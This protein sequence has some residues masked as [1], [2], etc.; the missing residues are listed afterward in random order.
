MVKEICGFQDS[1]GFFHTTRE[2][3]EESNYTYRKNKSMTDFTLKLSEEG[4]GTHYYW[5]T[6]LILKHFADNPVSWYNFLRDYNGIQPDVNVTISD[7]KKKKW[8]TRYL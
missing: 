7:K 5:E 2:E 3:A 6:E 4:V 1:K 8:W